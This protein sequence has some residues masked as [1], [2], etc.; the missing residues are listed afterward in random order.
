MKTKAKKDKMKKILIALDY[1]PAA[2]KVAEEGYKLCEAMNAE[3]TL[4]HVISDPSY[5]ASTI[6]DPI[7]GF[8]GYMNIDMMEPGFLVELKKVSMVFL[9][10]TKAHLGNDDI[11][12]IV[13]EGDFAE[14]ILEAAKEISADIIVMGSHSR[15]WLEKIVMGSTTEKVL[16][17][18]TI[19][20]FIIQT[21]KQD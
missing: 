2:Q 17:H 12:T 4:L 10:N 5:Y 15:K 1:H 7:M 6:Y 3:A 21:K 13:K 19:P 8:G 20:L 14:C 9:E 18:T 11:K 16:H